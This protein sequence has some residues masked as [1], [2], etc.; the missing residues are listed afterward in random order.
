MRSPC[1][2]NPFVILVTVVCCLGTW[3]GCDSSEPEGGSDS[4]PLST[5]E[6]VYDVEYKADV[7]A[8][9]GEALD[10][11]VEA[12]TA[13]HRYVFEAGALGDA[14]VGSVL[15]VAQHDLGRIVSLDEGG[16][17]VTVVL[18]PVP[19]NEAIE[20][21]RIGWNLAFQYT[22]ESVDR[23]TVGGHSPRWNAR[24]DTAEFMYEEGDFT[25]NVRVV[26][27]GDHADV[28]TQVVKGKGE[29]LTARISGEGRIEGINSIANAIYGN[30]DLENFTFENSDLAGQMDLELVTAASGSA[31]FDF[32]MPEFAVQWPVPP[33]VMPIPTTIGIGVQFVA[34]FE[35]S[36]MAQATV[37]SGL[38]FSGDAGFQFEEA[39]VQPITNFTDPGFDQTTADASAPIGIAVDA[40]AGVAFPRVSLNILNQE[41]AFVL[42]GMTVGSRLTW[43]PICK[44]SYVRLLVQG[45][46]K[47]ELLGVTIA[48][49]DVIL[50]DR[51]RRGSLN[52]CAEDD[53]RTAPLDFLAEYR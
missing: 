16:G 35:V 53:G 42:T 6:V 19:L 51:Q 37:T 41:V 8:I 2:S 26:P 7:L 49:D 14:Q 30:G 50:F 21:G 5:G 34:S 46:Y 12:D 22:P 23:M 43:G 33:N 31:P 4:G 11:L 36:A 13:Q 15:V 20:N 17:Q 52:D 39:E 18:E 3:V 40:Q 1:Y 48:E 45:G 44:E 29:N 10:A 25:I 32:T 27:Q 47:L 38:S 9:E 24:Q 28:M